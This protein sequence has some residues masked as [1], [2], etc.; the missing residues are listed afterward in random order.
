M[1]HYDEA[2]RNHKSTVLHDGIKNQFI[3]ERGDSI[4]RLPDN[5]IN[6][7]VERIDSFILRHSK[8]LIPGSDD[9]KQ[10]TQELL[11]SN[12]STD[13]KMEFNL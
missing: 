5:E 9:R 11:M 7:F 12:I 8:L 2:V 1:K 3:I 13:E 10:N 4:L 6:T